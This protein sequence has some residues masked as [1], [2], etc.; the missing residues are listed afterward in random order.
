MFSLFSVVT[1]PNQQCTSAS[2]TTSTPVYGTCFSQSECNAKGGSADGN[3]AA[4]FG[5][6]CTFLV[7]TCGSSVTNNCTYVQNPSY[8]SAYST[9]GS[10]EYNVMPQSSDICQL[11]LDL[12]NFD[13]SESTAGAC[14]DTFDV[15]VGS[16]RDYHTLCGTNSG[17][18]GKSRVKS[19]IFVRPGNG[20]K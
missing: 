18:H 10:C 17:Y 16:S 14:Q 5:V 15:T 20:Y 3:C 7:S 12:D 2:S 13:L 19:S 9:S 11:R 6:C 1:F 8:P 4:G